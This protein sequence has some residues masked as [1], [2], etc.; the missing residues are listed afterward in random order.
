MEKLSILKPAVVLLAVS[1]ALA[2]TA[3]AQTFT[4]LAN[5][6]S[7]GASPWSVVQGFNGNF[8]GT[9]QGGGASGYGA[10]FEVPPQGE[11]SELYSFCSQ[12]DCAD[13]EYP[14]GL[15]QATDG[16]FYGTTR[17][18]APVHMALYSS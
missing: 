4:T 12:P 2:I 16:N 14:W 5:F 9:T 1:A 13:G 17:A 10:V 3:S 6:D 11:L 18:P 7:T 15:V 8:Y